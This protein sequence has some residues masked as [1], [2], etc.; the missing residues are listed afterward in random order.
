MASAPH[1]GQIV[2]FDSGVHRP[3]GLGSTQNSAPLSSKQCIVAL[4]PLL[5]SFAAINGRMSGASLSVSSLG[6]RG[7]GHHRRTARQGTGRP[8]CAVRH[9]FIQAQGELKMGEHGKP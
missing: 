4:V 5:R 1:L 2:P 8:V 3:G 6:K 9:L 7:Q